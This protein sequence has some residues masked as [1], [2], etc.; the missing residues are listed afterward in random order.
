MLGPIVQSLLRRGGIFHGP[1]LIFAILAVFILIFYFSSPSSSPVADYSPRPVGDSDPTNGGKDIVQ[2]Y[3]E[4][5]KDK[6][7]DSISDK[8]FDYL[9]HRKSPP[10]SSATP[11]SSAVPKTAPTSAASIL[12]ATEDPICDGLAKAAQDLLVIVDT[13]VTDLHT[14]LPARLLT[15]LRCAPVSIFSTVSLKLG[16][17]TVHDALKEVSHQ[18]RS[19]YAS[20]FNH[21]LDQQRAQEIFQDLTGITGGTAEL[22]KWTIIPA[23]VESYLMN[24]EKKFFFLITP[25]TYV[26]IPNL[27]AWLPHL[28][29]STPMYVGAQRGSDGMEVAALSTGILISQAAMAQLAEAYITRK[30]A[31]EENASKRSTPDAVLGEAFSESGVPLTRGF[32][33]FQ[34]DNLLNTPFNNA[35]WC[36]APV[37]WGSMT[38]ALMDLMWD[39]DRNWTIEH[40]DLLIPPEPVAV[41]T[42][43]TKGRFWKRSPA[44]AVPTN[45]PRETYDNMDDSVLV[46]DQVGP[47]A[48]TIPEYH[49]SHLLNAIV[50]PILLTTPNR[51][52]WDNGANTYKID[53][54]S[55]QSGYG[56][57]QFDRCSYACDVR[58]KCIMYV[59]E[60]NECRMAN[61]LR[62]GSPITNKPSKPESGWIF[63]RVNDYIDG[64]KCEKN[65][66]P[67]P[68]IKEVRAKTPSLSEPSKVENKAPPAEETTS[69]AAQ[70]EL[71]VDEGPAE[72]A[73][74]EQEERKEEKKEEEKPAP[75]QGKPLT[76]N[77][78]KGTASTAKEPAEKKP[79]EKEVKPEPMK[80]EEEQER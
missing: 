68:A 10:K 69:A 57:S 11:T 61:W 77:E 49:Y 15:H 20:A 5:S 59:Y 9:G 50:T 56:H 8:L 42:T 3:T 66:Q 60:S 34:G 62:L 26:S 29:P 4:H 76:G 21:Y 25:T 53:G 30:M 23:L 65:N 16:V 39:F 67:F 38:P 54:K 44:T 73:A 19:K 35:T 37:A 48:P 7:A 71:E 55:K 78:D 79:E 63:R 22:G 6:E 51:T 2:E 74:E 13:P 43:T 24:P 40:R 12:T 52:M 18:T 32:P 28:S 41:S 36:K 47:V 31:W 46:V 64:L 75:A 14:T 45:I 80:A 1:R 70:E 17:H 58:S 72:D 33:A 27:L